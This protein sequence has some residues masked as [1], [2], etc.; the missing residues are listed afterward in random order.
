ML[1]RYLVEF[2]LL[3]SALLIRKS[4]TGFGTSAQRSSERRGT[5]SLFLEM[6]RCTLCPAKKLPKDKKFCSGR[7][8]LTYF[9]QIR[10]SIR[11]VRIAFAQP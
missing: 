8:T 2:L 4:P 9:G 11:Q 1:F 3:T 6:G 7:M 5:S 10:L